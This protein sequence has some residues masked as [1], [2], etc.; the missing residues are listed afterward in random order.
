MEA[1]VVMGIHDQTTGDLVSFTFDSKVTPADLEDADT[2]ADSLTLMQLRI[3]AHIAS[4]SW[5]C[6]HCGQPDSE[7]FA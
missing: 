6:A 5:N 4:R 7:T 2:D 1:M 3:Q